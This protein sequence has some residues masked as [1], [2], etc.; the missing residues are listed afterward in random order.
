MLISDI[1][2][3]DSCYVHIQECPRAYYF[4]IDQ[5]LIIS[6]QCPMQQRAERQLATMD[7]WEL[8]IQC[9]NQLS[10]QH[11]RNWAT[12]CSLMIYPNSFL[13]CF[14]II[15]YIEK[16]VDFEPFVT[17]CQVDPNIPREWGFYR[18]YWNPTLSHKRIRKQL[19]NL[20]SL[21]VIPSQ[22]LLPTSLVL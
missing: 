12:I 5:E 18:P 16:G 4:I 19:H 10:C 13:R 21:L 14:G 1:P 15:L 3:N 17:N 20:F 6:S 7:E 2:Y 9:P 11:V 22:P 8:Y